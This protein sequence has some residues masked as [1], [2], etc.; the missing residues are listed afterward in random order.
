MY[1]WVGMLDKDLK[2]LHYISNIMPFSYK[3]A[4]C[5]FFINMDMFRLMSLVYVS[6]MLLMHGCSQL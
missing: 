1:L 2:F 4:I 6:L 5:I 3:Q